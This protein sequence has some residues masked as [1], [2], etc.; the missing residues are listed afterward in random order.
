MKLILLDMN[1]MKN[2]E[3]VHHYLMEQLNFPQHYEKNLDAL[4]EMLTAEI[5]ENFCLDLAR[6]TEGD[7]PL[8]EFEIRLEKVLEDAA[9][10]V[11]EREGHFYA[12]FADFEPLA[13][14][15]MW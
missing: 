11:E 14:S 8:R 9:Q 2:E 4:R 15:S 12:V 5:S 10:S 6:C 13:P 3:A 7:A 1:K